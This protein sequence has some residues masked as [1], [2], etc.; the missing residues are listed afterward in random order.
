MRACVRSAPSRDPMVGRIWR[1]IQTYF[2]LAGSVKCYVP[3]V[4]LGITNY[5]VLLYYV[6]RPRPR[7]VAYK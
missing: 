6:V 4:R 3:T 2:G 1:P 5:E 7:A